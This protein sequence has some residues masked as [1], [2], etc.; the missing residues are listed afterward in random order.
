MRPTKNS[1][2]ILAFALSA[3]FAAPSF[4]SADDAPPPAPASQD[5]NGQ[6]SYIYDLKKLVEKSKENIKRV[7]EKIKEQAIYKRNL[8][9]EGKAREYYERAA[10]LFEEGRVNEARDLWEKS[11]RITE[12]PEMKDYIKES[13]KRFKL[14]EKAMRK[15][16][17]ERLGR[18]A[19]D[20]K[21]RERQV[22]FGLRLQF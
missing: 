10:R 1:I 5:H 8:L 15:E 20:D 2:W 12:H 9:R 18:L 13:E 4:V 11:I 3:F 21:V 6:A 22:R 19:V 7:N 17:D 16:E 14:Q